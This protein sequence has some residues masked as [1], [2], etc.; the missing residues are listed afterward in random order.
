MRACLIQWHFQELA[1]GFK[2]LLGIGKLNLD[3]KVIVTS[4]LDI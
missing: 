1:D 3:R 4:V 2:C